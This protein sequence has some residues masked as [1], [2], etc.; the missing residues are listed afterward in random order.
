MKYKPLSY[1]QGVFPSTDTHGSVAFVR[2]SASD[3]QIP[4]PRSRSCLS[5]N[6]L[7][8]ETLNAVSSGRATM[9][10]ITSGSRLDV[11]SM[12]VHQNV[13]WVSLDYLIVGAG[14][15]AGAGADAGADEK[16]Q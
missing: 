12:A 14:A 10:T 13:S 8:V 6:T 3:N 15:G 9:P 5:S 7:G 16:S 11:S 4:H 2:H 1:R